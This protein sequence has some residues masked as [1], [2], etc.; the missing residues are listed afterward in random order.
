MKTKKRIALSAVAAVVVVLCLLFAYRTQ[1]QAQQVDMKT[2][3]FTGAPEAF[4]TPPPSNAAPAL[5][6]AARSIRAAVIDSTPRATQAKPNT[7]A[8]AN[9]HARNAAS[10]D[11]VTAPSAAPVKTPQQ[12]LSR[13]TDDDPTQVFQPESVRYHSA[14]QAEPVD[15]DW[16]SQAQA[17][18]QNFF[19]SELAQ[20][21]PYVAADCRTDLCELQIVTDGTDAK[22]FYEALRAFKQQGF[23]NALNFDQDTGSI[24]YDGGKT[25][26]VY[27]FS[28]M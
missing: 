13:F 22:M 8:P 25:V 28:R 1:H 12:L 18:L 23:W 5:K 3:K 7:D 26:L 14:V 4:A 9:N 2:A 20:Y 21:N 19:S 6:N 17:E 15:P 11:S 24:S 10:S 16:G 27:F